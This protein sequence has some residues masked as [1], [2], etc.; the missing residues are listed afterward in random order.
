MSRA[1]YNE[2]DPAAAHLLRCLIEDGVIATGDVDERSIKDVQ[3]KDLKGYTQCHFFAG[4]GLW[5][6]AARL[7]GWP[8][9]RELWT[10]SCPCQPFSVAGKGKGKDDSRHLWPDFLRLVRSCRPP[11]VLGEQ[12]AGKAGYDWF[13]GVRSD[14][15]GE[16]Y[17][18][19]AVDIPA[20][21]A[22]APHVRARLY[23]IATRDVVDAEGISN[24]GSLQPRQREGISR[25]VDA[26]RGNSCSDLADADRGGC[27]G[28]QEEPQWSE[29]RR[30]SP[31]WA[32]RNLA[33]AGSR[34]GWRWEIDAPA[35]RRDVI[36]DSRKSSFWS[37]AIW[38]TG[39]DGK[40]RRVKPGLRLLAHGF[41]NRVAALRIAGNAIVPQVAAEVIAAL[42]ETID[43]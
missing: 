30:A 34:R 27:G 26:G 25:L 14:L 22:D 19:R 3:P 29:E 39:A 16:G 37:N 33:D 38:L 36:C 11:V 23:W 7:A 24:N 20:C 28:R 31:E 21:S 12:V 6:V 8:D 40:A 35:E 41:P 18:S 1:Y 13:D 5:S 10:G 15:E 4:G 43:E 9:D 2:I 42:M 17:S 32:G